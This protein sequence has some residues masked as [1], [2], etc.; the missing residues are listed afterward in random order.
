MEIM[1]IPTA[2]VL[3]ARLRMYQPS[4]KAR[5]IKQVFETKYGICEVDG[6]I[7]QVHADLIEALFTNAIKTR[8]IDNFIEIMIDPYKV[9]KCLSETEYSY[10]TLNNILKDLMK[11]V[12]TIK[13]K[14]SKKND[15]IAMGT[16]ISSVRQLEKEIENKSVEI[17]GKKRKLWVVRLGDVYCQLIEKDIH[18]HYKTE[19]INK[20]KSGITQAIIRFLLT[21][22]DKP[23]GGWTLDYCIKSVAGEEC[24]AAKMTEYRQAVRKEIDGI[25]NCGFVFENDRFIAV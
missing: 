7:G 19:P 20:L 14:D 17:L 12:I 1:K 4:K 11:T 24:T 13:A 9:R 6:R 5:N 10:Q 22:K 15:F 8:E 21:H 23:N 16:V 25:K 2:T 3:P 18:L